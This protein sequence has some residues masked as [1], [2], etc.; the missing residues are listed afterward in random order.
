MGTEVSLLDLVAK[1]DVKAKKVNTPNGAGAAGLNPNASDDE[2]ALKAL[3][4]KYEAKYAEPAGKPKTKKRKLEYDD[5]GEGY[6]ESDPF[7][8]NSECFDEVVPQEVTTAHGGFY[9]N[10]GSLEFKANDKAV[11]E[12]SS[13]EEDIKEK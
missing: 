10:T 5:I 12:L 1:E 4:A 11:F 6:D 8:D 7:I 13:D 9:I 2:D 3:A